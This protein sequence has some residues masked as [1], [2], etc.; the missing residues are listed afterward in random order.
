MDLSV[1]SFSAERSVV[2]ARTTRDRRDQRSPPPAIAARR[3]AA[4]L[5][6]RSITARPTRTASA[7]PRS[8]TLS[9]IYICVKIYT[10]L[11]NG[12]KRVL[13]P[14]LGGQPHGF[15]PRMLPAG[16]MK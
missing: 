11:A 2:C 5:T 15:T 13:D 10:C 1:T 6:G 7:R 3:P 8:I 9:Y 4:T 16:R 14:G 12:V